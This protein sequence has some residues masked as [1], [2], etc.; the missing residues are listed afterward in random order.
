MKGP[1]LGLEAEYWVEDVH[2]GKLSSEG[3]QLAADLDPA[4]A[5]PEMFACQ[6]ELRTPVCEDLAQLGTAWAAVIER[7][8]EAAARRGL[9]LRSWGVHP[10]AT[11]AHRLILSPGLYYAQVRAQSG[12]ALSGH[13]TCGV[14]VHAGGTRGNGP[15]PY[16]VVGSTRWI[17]PALAA[18]SAPQGSPRAQV[19]RR[20]PRA[21]LP[22]ACTA[23]REY[24]AIRIALG[25]R[26]SIWWDARPNTN[27][28]TAELR[29]LDPDG[30]WDRLLGCAAVWQAAAFDP[31]AIAQADPLRHEPVTAEAVLAEHHWEATMH[32]LDAQ[33]VRH[34]A[35][36]MLEAVRPVLVRLGTS[37]RTQALEE[38]LKRHEGD[39]A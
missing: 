29:C 15:D 21:G 8:G 7:A 31:D 25:T 10:E 11:D 5:T 33:N 34:L 23:A 36:R 27:H 6:L 12:P 39:T 2:T 37:D 4:G 3:P 22:P 9:V 14:H 30:P 35:R 38:E 20:L 24:R 28:A 17:L 18:F 1:T 13:A 19:R 26:R 16:Y 32:G